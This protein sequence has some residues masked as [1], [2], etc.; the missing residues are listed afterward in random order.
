MRL[1]EWL[2]AQK[3][4]NTKFAELL[5]VDKSMVGRWVSGDVRPGWDTIPRII[6]ATGGE[7]TANDFLPTP[8]DAG[9]GDECGAGPSPDAR[10]GC[11][12]GQPKGQM[13]SGH[14][15]RAVTRARLSA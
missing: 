4:S 2:A 1:G 3:M 5:G 9:A 11:A 12:S 14:L 8:P 7:V 6:D 15:E 10:P 13:E